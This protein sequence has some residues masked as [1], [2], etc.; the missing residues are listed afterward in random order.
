MPK[1]PVTAS[2]PIAPSDALAP[3]GLNEGVDEAA[4]GG[5]GGEVVFVIFGGFG[6]DAMFEGVEARFGAAGRGL[7][8]GVA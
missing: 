5:I 7:L 1:M 6:E 3:F 8:C 4:L 2:R